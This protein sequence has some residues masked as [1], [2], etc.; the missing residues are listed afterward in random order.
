MYAVGDLG[1]IGVCLG[2]IVMVVKNIL[3]KDGSDCLNT[4]SD[5]HLALEL[6][7]PTQGSLYLETN[8]NIIEIRNELIN[9]ILTGKDADL[10]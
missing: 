3:N 1:I 5:I 6:I 9:V 10:K 8:G 7:K 2:I 4:M